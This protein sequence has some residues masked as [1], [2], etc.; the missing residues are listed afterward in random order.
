MQVQTLL[1]PANIPTFGSL[2][3]Q[4]GIAGCVLTGAELILLFW[5]N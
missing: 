4:N 2:I 5:S 3:M 1:L